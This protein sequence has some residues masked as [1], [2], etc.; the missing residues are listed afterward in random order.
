MPQDDRLLLEVARQ[1]YSL[2]AW[3][4]QSHL[5]RPPSIQPDMTI[6]APEARDLMNLPEQRLFDAL[7]A[8]FPKRSPSAEPSQPLHGGSESGSLFSSTEGS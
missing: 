3:E 4:W 5:F 2:L 8:A 1:A 7:C 6:F